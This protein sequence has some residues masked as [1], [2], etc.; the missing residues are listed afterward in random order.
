MA[1]EV[2]ARY[3]GRGIDETINRTRDPRREI[4]TRR[5]RD[6][7]DDEHRSE[8][9]ARRALKGRDERRRGRTDRELERRR[10][11]ALADNHPRR[12]AGTD[13]A[14]A[15]EKRFSPARGEQSSGR[16]VAH[17]QNGTGH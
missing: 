14:V 7:G 11:Y 6:Q 5:E 8:P 12:V 15:I 4:R 2:A 13:L 3:A 9:S 16:A 17:D 10:R 1:L